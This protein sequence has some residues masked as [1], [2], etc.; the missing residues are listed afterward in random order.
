LIHFPLFVFIGYSEGLGNP[1]RLENYSLTVLYVIIL[2]FGSWAMKK[3]VEDNVRF[4]ESYVQI[5]LTTLTLSLGLLLFKS[6]ILSL[7]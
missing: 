1:S 5:F 4:R 6:Q 7:G 3:F 2:G